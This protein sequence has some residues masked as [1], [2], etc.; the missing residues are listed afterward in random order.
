MKNTNALTYVTLLLLISFNFQTTFS[1]DLALNNYL[2]PSSK[3]FSIHNR[4]IVE[5]PVLKDGSYTYK[6][7]EKNISVEIRDGFYYEYHPKKEY[8]K[9][10]IEWI[11]EF[12]Y[13]LVVVDIEKRNAPLKVG[14][15]LISQIIKIKEDEYFYTFRLNNKTGKGSFKKMK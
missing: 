7:R 8:I 2:R 1:Q 3:S 6:F 15:E 12:K 4:V 11:T 9:A 5:N 14:S 13:K 10:K